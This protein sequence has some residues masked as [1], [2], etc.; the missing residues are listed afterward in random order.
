MEEC[1][2]DK[3]EAKEVH[4]PDP[5]LAAQLRR[6]QSPCLTT[7]SDALRGVAHCHLPS[8]S[9]LESWGNPVC[10]QAGW[11][12]RT[13]PGKSHFD[14]VFE[15]STKSSQAHS[16]GCGSYASYL[17]KRN[18]LLCDV[19]YEQFKLCPCVKISKADRQLHARQIM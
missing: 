18:A 16:R 2:Q 17:H 4:H 19:K 9:S 3:A 5:S 11:I 14:Q 8:C 1:R 13:Q 6:P 7:E 10:I 12:A 15:V